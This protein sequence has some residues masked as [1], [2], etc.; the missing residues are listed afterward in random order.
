[1]QRYFDV[2]RYEGTDL[3]LRTKITAAL[4]FIISIIL[5][6]ITFLMAK[7]FTWYDLLVRITIFV[8]GIMIS[9]V[10]TVHTLA[11]KREEKAKPIP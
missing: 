4:W 11:K 9:T 3:W 7:E 2:I 1:M 10:F 6:I 5:G 8:I